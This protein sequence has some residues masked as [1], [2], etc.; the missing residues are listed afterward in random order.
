MIKK[1]EIVGK[2]FADLKIRR[3]EEREAILKV[4]EKSGGHAREVE[5]KTISTFDAKN[6]LSELIA[7]AVNGEPQIITKNGVKSVV[8]ISY[9]DYRKLT[10]KKNSLVEFLPGSPLRSS[11]LDLSR[12]KEGPGRTTLRSDK[13]VE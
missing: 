7:A 4:L 6:K 3:A 13:E 11:E 12:S 1:E 10:A 9:E 8:L 2:T 5:M